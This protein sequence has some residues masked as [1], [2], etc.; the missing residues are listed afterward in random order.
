V[1]GPRFSS[2][3]LARE[4]A[5]VRT[6]AAVGISIAGKRRISTKVNNEGG[7]LAAERLFSSDQPPRAVVCGSDELAIG[8]MEYVLAKGLRIPQDVAV[9]GCDGLPHSRSDLINLTSVVQPLQEMA[10]E[11]FAMLLRRID[12]PSNT[13]NSLIC[14]H[15]LHLGRTCGCNAPQD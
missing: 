11:A 12:A 4:Q 14:P 6:A 1:I 8:V 9:A 5:F 7:R 13:Y 10:Q 3:S 15:R 2:A